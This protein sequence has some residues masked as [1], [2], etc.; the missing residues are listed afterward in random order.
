MGVK[1]FRTRFGARSEASTTPGFNHFST[2]WLTACVISRPCH[3][4]GPVANSTRNTADCVRWAKRKLVQGVG[5]ARRPISQ[6]PPPPPRLPC[7]EGEGG[8]TPTSTA[9][10]DPHIALIILTTHVWEEKDW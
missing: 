9:Q 5:V 2:S 8:S 4:P 6:P 3:R 1:R 7:P 10:N